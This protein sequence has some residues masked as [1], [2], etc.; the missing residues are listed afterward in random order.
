MG[1][2]LPKPLTYIQ[3]EEGSKNGLK[4]TMGAMQGWRVDMEDAHICK[5]GLSEK[6]Q[7]VS[8]FTVFD[9]H[10]GKYV[11]EE[12]A[13]S[14]AAELIE[15]KPFNT[16]TGTNYNV[17]EVKKGLSEAFR[18]WDKTLRQ[19]TQEKG[20]RSGCTATGVLITPKHFFFF[21]IGDSRTLLVHNREVS[22]ASED[23]KPTNDDEKRRIENAGGRV[24]IQRING[25]LAVSRA[26]GDFDYKTKADLPDNEQLVSPEPDVTVV[27]R[28]PANDNFIL[29]ACDGIYDVMENDQLKDF[30]SERYTSAEDQRDITND[31]LDLC[32]HKNSRDNMSAILISLENPPKADATKI[33]KFKEVDEKIKS[34]MKE[35]LGQGD[36]QRPTID[37]VVGHFDEKEYIKN[38]DEIGGV[39]ASLA[40]RGYITRSY[41]STIANNKLHA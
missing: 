12:S 26:L 9:G 2:F 3:S 24:M 28:D 15:M 36:G 23:H 32:L 19:K 13:A 10:A 25:S 6:L 18:Q 27:Q 16:M 31:L 22:F 14:F 35:Y 40:K 4:W 17:E 7:D 37:Q 21:N 29:V 30:I 5:I 34:D 11:A 39:P 20:D 8:M 38:A 41:E 1:A 33:S